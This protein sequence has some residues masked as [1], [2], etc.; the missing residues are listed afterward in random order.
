[1]QLVEFRQAE[2]A[3]YCE[4]NLE[5]LLSAPWEVG[6]SLEWTTMLRRSRECCGERQP[7]VQAEIWSSWSVTSLKVERRLSWF[8][9]FGG[10]PSLGFCCHHLATPSPKPAEE[11]R[12]VGGPSLF[13]MTL[14]RKVFF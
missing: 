3:R 5:R 1:M 13:A 9:E 2:F 8:G 6:L 7:G 14:A 10:A 11:S 12:T 4:D